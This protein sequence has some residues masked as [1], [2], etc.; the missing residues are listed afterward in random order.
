MSVRATVL[1]DAPGPRGRRNNLI[2]TVLTAVVTVAV[3]GWI[4]WTLGNNGQ[5][6]AAKWTP[7]LDSLTWRTYILPGLWGT[8]KSAFVS[9]ILAM[10]LGVILGL[11]RLSE[12]APVRWVCGVIVEFFRAI[13]VL[14]LMIFAYQLFAIYRMVPPRE[15]AFAAVVFGLTMYNGSVIAEI[16]RSGI[17]SLPKGQTEAARALGMSHSQTMRT[18][19]LPQAIAAM[20]PALVAQMVIALKDSALGYQIGYVE[21]VRS[22]I[23]T[24]SVNQ[25]FLASLTVVA[26][27]MILI[28]WAL[29]SLAQRIERQLRAGRARRNIVAKVPE[30]PDQGLDTKDNVNVDWHDPDYVEI[31]NP[32]Q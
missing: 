14:L 9:I 19:L 16:L 13:P 20:L 24:A 32:G 4:G 12:V 11:G 3:L 6:E 18:I 21:V 10:I 17:K 23:Q 7:F 5:L 25:N 27:I 30:L 1:Y 26:I 2:F 8:L 31:K 28:N 29:T 22:G 15:L